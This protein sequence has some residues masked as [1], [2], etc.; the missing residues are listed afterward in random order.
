MRACPTT[1]SNISGC[2][3][4]PCSDCRRDS[5]QCASGSPSTFRRCCRRRVSCL[6]GCWCHR[7]ERSAGCDG[8]CAE[9]S[10]DQAQNGRVQQ[11]R[12]RSG[13]SH[14]ARRRYG[15]Y[16]S[17]GHSVVSRG[18][19]RRHVRTGGHCVHGWLSAEPD[20]KRAARPLAYRRASASGR[21]LRCSVLTPP[22]TPVFAEALRRGYLRW[23]LCVGGFAP[24]IRTVVAIPG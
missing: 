22:M 18:C 21:Y 4:R 17:E 13:F 6:I 12:S 23:G 1:L 3:R 14:S 5:R 10:G 7:P 11:S 15:S 9:R 24:L 19:R 16:E 8:I 2:V 20:T